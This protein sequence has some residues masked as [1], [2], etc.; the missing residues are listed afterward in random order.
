MKLQE[1]MNESLSVKIISGYEYQ[2]IRPQIVCRDGVRLS[3]QASDGHYSSPR[4]NGFSNYESVEVGYP[5]VRP[6]SEW[7][8]YFDGTW[9]DIS[10]YGFIK[11]LT[12]GFPMVI[13]AYKN[14]SLSRAWHY[15]TRLF[16][17][18]ATES[19]YGYVPVGLVESFIESH[20]GIDEDKTFAQKVR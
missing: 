10:F 3:V 13:W 8:Q 4:I 15:F 19:V 18:N 5:S 12:D 17:D 9:Q 20:G 7:S 1:F 2:E 11:N 6:S 16:A 14:V